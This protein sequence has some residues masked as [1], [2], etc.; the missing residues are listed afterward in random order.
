M[1]GWTRRLELEVA[2]EGADGGIYLRWHFEREYGLWKLCEF[3]LDKGIKI[4]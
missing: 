4:L 1:R 3:V 2:D